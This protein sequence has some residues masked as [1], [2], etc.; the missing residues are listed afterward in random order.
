MKQK[1]RLTAAAVILA[2]FLAVWGGMEVGVQA[3]N[4]KVT[5]NGT[6]QVSKKKTKT[7]TVK[8][9]DS[10][11]KNDSST[12]NSK[13]AYLSIAYSAAASCSP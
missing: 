2:V 5:I 13:L 1:K 9:N 12:F 4:I 7:F 10:Y 3:Q 8:R 11:F 6:E